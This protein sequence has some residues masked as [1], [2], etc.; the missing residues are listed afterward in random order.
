M[1]RMSYN[2]AMLLALVLSNTVLATDRYLLNA[3]DVLDISVWN[4][5]TLKKTVLVLP[6]GTVSFPLAGE[7]IAKGKTVSEL[8]QAL[9]NNLS[10]FLADP[11][12][13]VVVANVSG[14]TVHILGKVQ[15]P[16]S[17]VMSQNLNVMQALSLAGGLSAYAKENNIIVLRQQEANQTVIK[18]RYA[19][20]K[21]GD[22][23]STNIKLNSGDV[24][25]IP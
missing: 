1:K 17:F 23:I 24:I 15:T 14:N 10:E 4:E 6:D 11:V 13:T 3:G 9:K 25:V 8:E 7:L 16:G 19:D 2:I 20:I 18:V 12:V 5:E 21:D 22:D